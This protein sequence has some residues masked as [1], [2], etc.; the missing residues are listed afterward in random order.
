[1][2]LVH[3]ANE[4]RH[5]FQAL[6]RNR[7]SSILLSALMI[8]VSKRPVLRDEL[9]GSAARTNGRRTFNRLGVQPL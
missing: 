1:M 8:T 3:V 7:T 2:R 6:A 9:R 5:L 4:S